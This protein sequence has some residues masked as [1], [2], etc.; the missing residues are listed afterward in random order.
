[1]KNLLKILFVFLIV[2]ISGCTNDSTKEPELLCF[3]PPGNFSFEIADK[4]TGANLFTNRT[5]QSNQIN[6]IDIATNTIVPFTFISENG[7]N[8]FTISTIGWKT[9]KVNYSITIKE[10]SIFGLYVDASI[11]NGTCSYTKYNEI[12]IK[13]AEFELNKNTG[14]YKILVP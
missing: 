2:I 3:T 9:E 8:I 12:L 14:V 7:L 4:T 10:K 1:M 6:I 13:N 11:I 5:F